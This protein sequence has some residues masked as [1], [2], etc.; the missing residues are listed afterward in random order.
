M[1]ARQ[2]VQAFPAAP[3]GNDQL[4]GGDG[5][6]SLSGGAGNNLLDG[7][8]G[9]D[10]V[11]YS[12][13][14]DHGVTVDLS[15]EIATDNGYGGT[16]TL[17]SIEDV[18][19]SNF[20][21]TIT[22]ADGGSQLYGLG[23]NDVINGGAGNDYIDGGTGDDLLNGGGGN[24]TYFFRAGDGND[25]IVNSSGNNTIRIGGGE[26]IANIVFTQSGNNLVIDYDDSVTIQN[27]F[28]SDPSA[29]TFKLAFDNGTS[30]DLTT[31]LNTA[32]PVNHP[33][34]AQED[35]FTMTAGATLTGNVLADNGHG[36]DSDPD[37]DALSIAAQT[38]QTSNGGMA[39]FLSSGDFTYINTTGFTGADTFDYTLLDGHGGS[40]T[41]T[42]DL[43]VTQQEA[44]SFS[45]DNVLFPMVHEEVNIA[46]LVPPGTPALGV[47]HGDLDAG[48]TAASATITFVQSVAGYANTL[49]S[50]EIAADGTITSAAIDFANGHTAVAGATATVSL[51]AGTQLG[52]FI[53]S[54]GFNANGGYSGI[55]LNTG[56]LNFIYDYGH[57]DQRAANIDDSGSHISL[58]YTD[59]SDH[60][61]V[62]QGTDY[63][64][65]E[66]G[67]STEI[68]TD[69][70]VHVIAGAPDAG[71]T[72]D[73]RIGFEDLPNTGDADYNDVI[74]DVSFH[75]VISGGP[76]NDVLYATG[77]NG[78][79]LTGGAGADR[80]VFTVLPTAAN[81]VKD[82]QPSE[83]D[84]LDFSSL[85]ETPHPA[86]AAIDQYIQATTQG[87]N[88]VIS[89]DP[90]GAANGSHFVAVAVLDH[91]T[92]FDVHA[93][94]ASGNLIV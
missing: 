90:D 84:K 61:T 49:G 38:V 47:I 93:L 51:D 44:H 64:T 25:T 42:V 54:N 80:F 12:S 75:D 94:L 28:T 14:T 30:F 15:Q 55:N 9:E 57:A 67:G 21:D 91:V 66:R 18:L 29:V 48:A 87:G 78:D 50:F 3:I 53:I 26:T 85:I 23:G 16:D 20:G 11:N 82:F 10:N 6:D 63:F 7:G 72:T 36:A 86:Q 40:A 69:D 13:V 24:D 79:V 39:V 45:S 34:V 70:A 89:V 83:G 52:L 32:P 59:A 19:G 92:G 58:V 41:G 71:H 43:T 74:A 37:G 5:N 4:Y 56:T 2:S 1:C 17:N 27:F 33:P 68:N 22:G 88:T 60:S 31:L 8:A 81:E 77:S 73:L 35:D 76:G 62:L 65:T 46:N